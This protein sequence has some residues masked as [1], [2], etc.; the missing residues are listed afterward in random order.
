MTTLTLTELQWK[1]SHSHPLTLSL[2][3]GTCLG[4]LGPNGV[5]KTSLLHTLIG[6]LP[7]THGHIHLDDQALHQLTPRTRAT[8]LGLLFQQTEG[9]LPETVHEHCLTS[10]YPHG[11]S[12]DDEH[13]I[14]QALS[15]LQ[16]LPLQHR[17]LTELSGGERRRVA[18]AALL[19][20]APAILLLDEPDTHL[21]LA[22]RQTVFAHLHA[23]TVNEQ[24][25][26]VLTLHDPNLAAQTCSH[27]LLLYPDGTWHYGSTQAVMTESHLSRLYGCQLTQQTQAFWSVT[28][29]YGIKRHHF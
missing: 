6:L 13:R 26:T 21:D 17:R 3:A 28:P 25:T 12:A 14:Q 19:V 10:R 11:H 27:L 22:H 29:N 5:G 16:L 23:L 1:H 24:R 7:P 4:I 2:P 9:W 20:Q 18:I 15:E 8:K